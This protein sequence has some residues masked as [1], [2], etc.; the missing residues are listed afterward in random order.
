MK[1][2]QLSIYRELTHGCPTIFITRGRVEGLVESCMVAKRKVHSSALI[3]NYPMKI[4]AFIHF[5]SP[6][7][8][9]VE[10]CMVAKSEC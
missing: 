5:K 10:S 2:T 3:G 6:C 9:L 4:N 7:W 8:G 1:S